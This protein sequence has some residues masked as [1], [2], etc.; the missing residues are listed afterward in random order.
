MDRWM[1]RFKS[2]TK[3]DLTILH[4]SK[5]PKWGRSA[6]RVQLLTMKAITFLLY[7][8][9][10]NTQNDV[11]ECPEDVSVVFLFY[12]LNGDNNQCILLHNASFFN[13]VKLPAAPQ[14][15]FDTIPHQCRGVEAHKVRRPQ[16]PSSDH[17]RLLW[18]TLLA[19]KLDCVW[20]NR[21]CRF[22]GF[23]WSQGGCIPSMSGT[24][25]C[26]NKKKKEGK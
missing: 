12:G 21:K 26:I 8:L 14:C 18:V 19:Q 15:A 22:D 20:Q 5:P 4:R 24:W 2:S 11:W 10:E 3:W 17:H 6:S 13:D 25:N 1:D 23:V 7:F 16:Q 9:R